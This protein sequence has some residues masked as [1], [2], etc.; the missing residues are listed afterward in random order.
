MSEAA[1]GPDWWRAS[2]GMWYPPESHPDYVA[3][4]VPAPT[5]GALSR[6]HG[7]TPPVPIGV[8]TPVLTD[9]RP[10][11]GAPSGSRS[12]PSSF[13]ALRVLSLAALV[14]SLVGVNL[15]WATSDAG[16]SG[17]RASVTGTGLG[18]GQ[19]LCAV[20][21][22]VLVFSWWHLAA[23]RP[24]TGIAL[25]ASWLGALALSVYEIV[26]IIAV[27]TRGLFTLNIGVGLHLCGFAAL[28]GSVCSLTDA[29]QLWSGGG[30]PGPVAPG[31]MWAGVLVTLGV[32][33]AASFFGYQAAASPVG[34]IPSLVP[35]QP[36]D[37]G[38]GRSGPA[39]GGSVGGTGSTGST[40]S[41]G[42]SG[43]VG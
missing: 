18:A 3:R 10:A 2:D 9:A 29:A 32:V 13:T 42:N 38:T 1:Q 22:V 11:G 6:P 14:L 24:H 40:G 26:D 15:A 7:E 12:A 43:N 16:L 23:P 39:G 36:F 21:A 27:P 5:G 30:S 34:S 37:N 41:T 4:R 35:D 31:A 19:L 25:F 33:A 28:V 20:L 8:G 17:L